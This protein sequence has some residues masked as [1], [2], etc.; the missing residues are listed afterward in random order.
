MTTALVVEGSVSSAIAC[1][2][3]TV[4]P[5]VAILQ[6]LVGMNSI[7]FTMTISACII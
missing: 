1:S 2:L 3:Q 5:F 4:A 6:G 7:R